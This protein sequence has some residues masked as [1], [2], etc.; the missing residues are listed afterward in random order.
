[1]VLF[2]G[3]VWILVFAGMTKLF[4]ISGGT[5]REIELLRRGF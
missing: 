1:M 3:V 5:F 2:A 4:F